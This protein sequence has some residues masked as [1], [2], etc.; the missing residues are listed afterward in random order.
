ML[1]APNTNHLQLSQSFVDAA[2][3]T[4]ITGPEDYNGGAYEGAWIC[5]LAHDRGR[6]FSAYDAYLKPAMRRDNLEV[7]TDA[8]A[9]KIVVENGR[10]TGVTVRRGDTEQTY[11][12]GGGVILAAGAFGSPQL[13]MLSGIGPADALRELGISIVANRRRLEPTCRITRLRRWSFALTE[14]TRLKAP[15]LHLTCYAIC[16]LS[17][18]C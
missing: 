11:R 3:A 5:Q 14:R 10:A 17:A 12:A 7:V 8:L 13:L 4:G 1:V 2:R 9:T 6:R 18:G 16:C 15:N